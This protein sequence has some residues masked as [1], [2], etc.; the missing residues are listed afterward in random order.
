MSPYSTRTCR[1]EAGSPGGDPAFHDCDTDRI[2]VDEIGNW[3]A[4]LALFAS[5][6]NP[7]DEPAR[8][9][10]YPLS[11]ILGKDV[12]LSDAVDVAGP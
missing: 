5:V 6:A 3:L 9:T 1:F 12:F 2:E 4:L 11:G 7:S 10:F 8:Y